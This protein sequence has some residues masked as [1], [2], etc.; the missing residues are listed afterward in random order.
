MQ[1]KKKQIWRT[2]AR[3]PRIEHAKKNQREPKLQKGTY[4]GK[5]GYCA[6]ILRMQMNNHAERWRNTK[7]GLWTAALRI[8]I[9]QQTFH[10]LGTE[11][12]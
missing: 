3:R 6:A 7:P 12:S 1:L 9:V 10:F 8:V 2:A 5:S 11:R 4:V